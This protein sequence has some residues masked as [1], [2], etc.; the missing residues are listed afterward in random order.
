MLQ[1]KKDAAPQEVVLVLR[2]AT[3]ERAPVEDRILILKPDN[4]GR[5]VVDLPSP[6]PRTVD[7][8][9]FQDAFWIRLGL[10]EEGGRIVALE[11]P[12]FFA[13]AT[14][15][16]RLSL[17]TVSI[18]GRPYPFNA[19]GVET[20]FWRVRM[21]AHIGH[22][23]FPPGAEVEA[24]VDVSNAVRNL[25]PAASIGDLQRQDHTIARALNDL[26]F[27]SKGPRDNVQAFGTWSPDKSPQPTG[28]A[29]TFVEPAV[30]YG[31]ALSGD[32]SGDQCPPVVTIQAGDKAI[33]IDDLAARLKKGAG[34]AYFELPQVTTAELQLLFPGSS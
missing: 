30:V 6:G 20:L 19:S 10:L 14:S 1:L 27:H 2:M 16:A 13:D 7:A 4:M 3:W 33:V 12:W 9:D 18:D 23:A 11:S 15:S 5:V 17:Q 24:T 34:R 28:V 29:F 8:L 31:V 22:F 21:G 25:A 32:S 26:A